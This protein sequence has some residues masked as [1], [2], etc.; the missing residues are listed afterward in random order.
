[1]IKEKISDSKVFIKNLFI[2][3]IIVV[4]NCIK[5]NKCIYGIQEYFF[6]HQ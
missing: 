3:I 5:N 2:K 4:K 6:I 1:M